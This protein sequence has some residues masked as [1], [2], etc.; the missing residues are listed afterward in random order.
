MSSHKHVTKA[1]GIVGLSTVVT[2]VLGFIRD[3]VIALA[4]GAGMEADAYFVAFRIPSMLRRLVG[5]GAL[6]VAFI[7]VFVEEHQQSEERA[8]ALSHTVTTLLAL[9]LIGLSLAGVVLMPFIV[10]GL[11]PG[12][13]EIPEKFELTVYL[14]RIT[15]PYILFISLAALAMGI[16][17]SLHHFLAPALAP[18]MLNLSLIGSVFFICPHLEQPVVGLAIGVLVGGITQLAFQIPALTRQGFHYR[19]SFD[20]H[21][22]AVRKIGMLLLPAFFGL[23]V[24]Q[25]SV[26]VNTLLASYLPEGSV[27]Y[28]YF[29]D[30][31]MEFPLG[32]FGIAI[33]TAVLPT[34]SLQSA[35]G[36]YDEL[37][38]TL[39]F[40]L[41]LVLFITIPSA[42]GLIVL[43]RPIVTFLFERG[44]F[45][46]IDSEATAMALL[47]Y[48]LGLSAI[49]SVRIIVPVFYSLK[50]TLTPVKC[51]AV[52][53]GIN[54]LC[55]LLLMKP[56]QHGGLA[57]ATTISAFFNLS[58][59]IWLLRKRFGKMNWRNIGLA[60][61]KVCAASAVMGL[62][63]APF[64]T[65][66]LQRAWFLGAA[67][68]VGI[69]VFVV[70]AWLIKSQELLFLYDMLVK[71]HSSATLQ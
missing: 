43:R 39:S 33:A 36:A 41:R 56:L 1:A 9:F 15:F 42:V 20:Y 49:A 21:N 44:K 8:W 29:A 45:T 2:R 66:A 14:T 68:V 24:N 57:L 7:P 54:I 51:A 35:K 65:L 19:P 37:M 13:Q 47:Y 28:L 59:L 52:S 10:R 71:R 63:C 31:V 34:M 40:A 60:T 38:D 67:I 16:L 25:I 6:T 23:A 69:G 48:T 58:L 26:F 46:A 61:G 27:S 30:R 3:M 12:F 53:V 55:S 22:P 11:A 50:D 62:C 18:I 5:E 17:N 32:I 4:F 64:T 70:C